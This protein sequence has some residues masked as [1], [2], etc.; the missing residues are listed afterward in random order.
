MSKR[1]EQGKER[2][3]PLT[4]LERA[5]Q[6]VMRQRDPAR[7]WKPKP[8]RGRGSRRSDV[9]AEDDPNAVPS[10]LHELLLGRVVA[11]TSAAGS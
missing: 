8:G 4:P 10:E 1:R 7:Q 6:E 2:T 11:T 5:F 3:A 9:R